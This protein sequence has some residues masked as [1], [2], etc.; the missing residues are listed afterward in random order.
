MPHRAHGGAEDQVF[1]GPVPVR[2]H[3]QQIRAFFPDQQRDG[4]F[5]RPITDERLAV[6]PHLA[7]C[8]GVFLQILH[9][10]I[11]F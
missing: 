9:I 6:V 4:F 7:E 8:P 3:D 5:G 10:G 1:E 2:T 11:G